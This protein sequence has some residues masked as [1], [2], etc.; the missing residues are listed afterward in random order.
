MPVAKLPIG[1]GTKYTWTLTA[2]KRVVCFKSPEGGQT[3]TSLLEVEELTAFHDAE[4]AQAT[5]EIN[6][7]LSKLEKS[8]KDSGR[9]LSLIE[10]QNRHLLVWATY[11]AVGPYDDEATIIKTLRLKAR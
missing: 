11:D 2:G 9:K 5:K 8:N 6:A 3:I 4:L 1:P 7:V 10:F